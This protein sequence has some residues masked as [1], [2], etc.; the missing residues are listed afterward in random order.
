MKKTLRPIAY[1][2]SLSLLAACNQQGNNVQ[3]SVEASNLPEASTD[4]V[5]STPSVVIIFSGDKKLSLNL[6]NENFTDELA[7]REVFAKSYLPGIEAKTLTLLQ[8][9]PDSATTVYA[10]SLGAV[11][12]Q[13]S[14]LTKVEEKLK[15]DKGIEELVTDSST[16]NQLNYQFSHKSGD[17]TVRE[18]CVIGQTDEAYL[19]CASSS[20][21]SFDELNSIVKSVKA[22]SDNPS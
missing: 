16:A 12:D 22:N 7:D 9:N 2:L 14:Y 10:Q 1:V 13:A 15:K 4:V 18:S 20:N 19:V 8:V 6:P 21:S 5:T 3:G 17:D 11:K